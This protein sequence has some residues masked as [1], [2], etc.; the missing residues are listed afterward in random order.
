MDPSILWV[1]FSLTPTH[2]SFAHGH[3]IDIGKYVSKARARATFAAQRISVARAHDEA[4]FPCN[5]AANVFECLGTTVRNMNR[6]AVF[7]KGRRGTHLPE[8]VRL[9][10]T[11]RLASLPGLNTRQTKRPAS[12]I[13]RQN[14]GKVS[15]KAGMPV[16]VG[17]F[18]EAPLAIA[19]IRKPGLVVRHQD[20]RLAVG[21][22]L[23]RLKV[24]RQDRL[25]RHKRIREESV[26]TL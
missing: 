13:G 17:T 7:E 8:P 3:V 5:K 15:A 12:A 1:S 18:S 25:R 24:W 2:A 20:R 6:S 22:L 19:A 21:P 26:R 16:T 11:I 23:R 10:R 4:M 9:L 14:E